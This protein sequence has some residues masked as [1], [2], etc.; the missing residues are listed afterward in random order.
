MMPLHDIDTE[1][2]ELTGV[3]VSGDKE[4]GCVGAKNNKPTVNST[5]DRINNCGCSTLTPITVKPR[6][7]K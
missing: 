3:Y 7:G 5:Y 2:H 4:R 6:R 1:T